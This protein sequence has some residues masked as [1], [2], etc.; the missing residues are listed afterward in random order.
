MYCTE[1]GSC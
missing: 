1:D